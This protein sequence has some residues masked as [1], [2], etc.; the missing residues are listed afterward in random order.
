VGG[1]RK[2]EQEEEYEER[3]RK[4]RICD[5]IGWKER[6]DK[7]KKKN[8]KSGRERKKYVKENRQMKKEIVDMKKS[9]HWKGRIKG[10]KED[11][12]KN[13]K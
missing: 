8:M 1:E 5:R 9:W 7:N 12:E 3:K 13:I 4:G 6:D 11:K 2:Q 10:K